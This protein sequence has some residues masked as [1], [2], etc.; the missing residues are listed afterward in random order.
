MKYN[1]ILNILALKVKV[2]FSHVS[3]FA[4]LCVDVKR[5]SAKHLSFVHKC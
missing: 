5:D 3:Y 2:G 4:V 1:H